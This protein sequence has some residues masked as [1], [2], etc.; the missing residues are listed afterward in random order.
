MISKLYY[1]KKMCT[2]TWEKYPNDSSKDVN[3]GIK[4]DF[5]GQQNVWYSDG[6]R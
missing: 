2:F 6:I 4:A 3:V 5:K 1:W